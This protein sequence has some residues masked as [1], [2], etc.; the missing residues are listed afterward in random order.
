MKVEMASKMVLDK[1]ENS[2]KENPRN[3]EPG[4]IYMIEY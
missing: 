3:R 2:N 4:C 1:H